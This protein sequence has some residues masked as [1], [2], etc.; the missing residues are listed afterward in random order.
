[1]DT[2]LSPNNHCH[3]L[4][5]YLQMVFP[6]AV[7]SSNQHAIL[8]N[9]AVTRNFM[10]LKW[11]H[12]WVIII[13]CMQQKN[14]C[15]CARNRFSAG[16][17]SN[18]DLY[19]NSVIG[20]TSNISHSTKIKQIGSRSTPRCKRPPD[21]SYTSLFQCHVNTGLSK[22]LWVARY[23]L[24]SRRVHCINSCPVQ[25]CGRVT[26]RVRHTTAEPSWGERE[27]VSSPWNLFSN[28]NCIWSDSRYIP[29]SNLLTYY[30]KISW[31]L[32]E[33]I[34]ANF[35]LFYMNEGQNLLRVRWHLMGKFQSMEQSIK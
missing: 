13:C 34:P 24:W 20:T 9:V 12:R 17:F 35:V 1:M 4:Y 21:W 25:N 19:N 7:T 3:W 27:E 33:L 10:Q 31:D 23:R 8:S 2:G 32:K 6:V 11:P 16:G 26:S 28:L 5:M 30:I 18:I 15:W 14:L 22:V 29:V